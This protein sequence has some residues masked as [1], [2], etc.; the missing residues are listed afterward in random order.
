MKA[1][2]FYLPIE[3]PKYLMKYLEK[4]FEIKNTN[5][6][7]VCDGEH[8]TTIEGKL[9]GTDLEVKLVESPLY[10]HDGGGTNMYYSGDEIY[11]S[12]IQGKYE[13]KLNTNLITFTIDTLLENSVVED[14]PV[15]LLV[16][17]AKI[18]KQCLNIKNRIE[19]KELRKIKKQNQKT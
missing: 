4:N 16:Q 13:L 7:N 17:A 5:V 14:I 12:L 19:K 8:K 11:L 9:R 2:R 6:E 18:C 3:V 1:I 15:E 10:D